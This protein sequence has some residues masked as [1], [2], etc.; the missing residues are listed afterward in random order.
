VFGREYVKAEFFDRVS[1]LAAGKW[2]KKFPLAFPDP[3]CYIVVEG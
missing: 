2:L 3:A 1:R